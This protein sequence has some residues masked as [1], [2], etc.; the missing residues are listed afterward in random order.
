MATVLVTGSAGRLGQAAI[1]E[2]VVQGHRVIG[3]DSRPTP[4]LPT[5]IVDT[6]QN[7]TLLRTL[8]QG[9]D[10][11]I[12]LAATPDDP[13]WPLPPEAG[14]NFL[15]QLVPNN[16]VPTYHILEAA[17]V[18]GVKKVILASSGQVVWD[19]SFDGP[20]PITVDAK[21]T[22]RWWYACTKVFL[23]SIGEAY[24]KQ[25]FFS[26]IAVRLGFC[27]RDAGQVK[28]ISS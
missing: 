4:G 25:K 15:S 12:H 17:R 28:L 8:M 10:A 14:D 3:L 6:L 26:V 13:V 18:A 23:E 21:L 16:L 2:L 27:P 22:P 7:P 1:A 9:V 20:Y 19:Q 24:A 5:A 11:V